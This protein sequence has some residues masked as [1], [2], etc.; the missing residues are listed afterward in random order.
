MTG[1]ESGTENRNGNGAGAGDGDGN[2]SQAR[3]IDRWEGGFG[4]IAYPDEAMQ[5]ASHALVADDGVWVVDP[6]DWDGLDD[7][8][9]ELGDVEGVC[10][11]LDRHERDAA[12]LARRHEVALH[13]PAWMNG[14]GGTLDRPVEPLNA[15]IGGYDV[16]RLVDNPLWQEAALYDGE[17]LYTPE[18][19]GTA[20]FFLA[21]GERV[22]V[23]PVLRLVPPADLADIHVERLL[24]GH[25]E[26]VFDDAGDAVAD[27][28]TYGR[29][30][31][32]RLYV[33]LLREYL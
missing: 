13:A 18:S 8:L 5:R 16:R 20:T 9:A 33:E 23:H 24:V 31:A 21:P 19:L 11:V 12:T 4:W 6:V 17:T 1:T 30:R 14:V 15:A 7:R 29:R 22:G 26:G 25:G 32:P 28:V 3:I 27:A 2:E 10:V